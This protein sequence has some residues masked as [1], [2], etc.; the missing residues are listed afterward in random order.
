[1]KERACM[2]VIFKERLDKWKEYKLP[3][4][5]VII[6][7]KSL[8]ALRSVHIFQFRIDVHFVFLIVRTKFCNMLKY[9]MNLDLE[10]IV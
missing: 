1:M 4:E 6:N 10:I 3:I 8:P 2:P 9:G 7:S 5:S